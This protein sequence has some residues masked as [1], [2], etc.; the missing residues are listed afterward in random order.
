M[1]TFKCLQLKVVETVNPTL[2]QWQKAKKKKKDCGVPADV[3]VEL[4]L[5]LAAVFV[6]LTTWTDS[7]QSAAPC[8]S[9][10]KR[11][12]KSLSLEN[13]GWSTICR[14][15]NWLKCLILNMMVGTRYCKNSDSSTRNVLVYYNLWL[16]VTPNKTG[17]HTE[18]KWPVWARSK[19]TETH[20]RTLV[21]PFSVIFNSLCHLSPNNTRDELEKI[22]R[23]LVPP[24]H[25]PTLTGWSLKLECVAR[26]A[27][28]IP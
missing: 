11:F 3:M 16:S 25:L 19:L 9:W 18:T 10:W 23:V 22:K 1:F 14:P 7:G 13:P 2:V 26:G 20:I 17:S 12:P 24:L 21:S 8:S 28:F 15:K 27:A 5:A 6:W 4:E